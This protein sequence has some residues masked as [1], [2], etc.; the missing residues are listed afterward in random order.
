MPSVRPKRAEAAEPPT[1]VVRRAGRDVIA[2]YTAGEASLTL[3]VSYPASFPLARAYLDQLARNNGL[4]A[5]RIDEI[6]R[7]LTAAE[8]GEFSAQ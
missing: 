4:A 7:G 2:V 3:R 6:R 1:F 5:N 8:K